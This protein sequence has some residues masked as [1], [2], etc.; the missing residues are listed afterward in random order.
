MCRCRR[1]EEI[2]RTLRKRKMNKKISVTVAK[3]EMTT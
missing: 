2:K 1:K 3:S